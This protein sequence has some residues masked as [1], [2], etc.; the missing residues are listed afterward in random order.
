MMRKIL[1][2]IT[3]TLI[4]SSCSKTLLVT[5]GEQGYAGEL[6][7]KYELVELNTVSSGSTSIFGVGIGERNKDGVITNL[8]GSNRWYPQSNF[9]RVLTLITYS[10]IL[11]IVTA[12]INPLNLIAGVA[13][14]G[15]LNNSTWI[16]TSSNEAMRS[17]NLELIEGNPNVD[18]F[19]YPKYNIQSKIGLFTNKANV[20]IISK[21]AKLKTID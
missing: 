5:Q 2:V 11:P 7:E 9:I 16:A 19:I 18:L 21:G 6:D 4:F 10:A 8:L 20:T 3:A 15:I 12:P 13:L 1:F 14:G 17:A